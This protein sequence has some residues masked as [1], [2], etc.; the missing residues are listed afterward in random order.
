MLK[1]HKP[2]SELGGCEKECRIK[3]LVGEE[4]VGSGLGRKWV[5]EDRQESERW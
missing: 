5:Y 1:Q 3:L 4:F 2:R